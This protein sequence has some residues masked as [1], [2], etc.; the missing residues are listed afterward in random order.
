M[1]KEDGEKHKYMHLQRGNY[2]SAVSSL[3]FPKH[4]LHNL[5]GEQHDD[6]AN[7]NSNFSSIVD[8][9]QGKEDMKP[10]D[11]C[12]R[13]NDE[14]VNHHE[15]T[16]SKKSHDS[17]IGQNLN[18]TCQEDNL[19]AS[20]CPPSCTSSGRVLYD[21]TMHN[22]KR[23]DGCPLYLQINS[24]KV[25]QKTPKD[26]IDRNVDEQPCSSGS[27][28]QLLLGENLLSCIHPSL[29][30][31]F[32]EYQ[33]LTDDNTTTKLHLYLKSISVTYFM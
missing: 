27:F 5:E 32:S 23:M 6:H 4:G 11:S 19:Y 21:E 7:I 8:N 3:E 18:G 2:E 16:G 30:Y 17:E 13:M 29:P 31:Q 14:L 24:W 15:A 28:S 20:E 26:Y 33:S 22:N 12:G 10:I 1:E 9:G 25:D